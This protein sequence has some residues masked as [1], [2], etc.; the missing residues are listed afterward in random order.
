VAPFATGA[1]DL[2]GSLS[3]IRILALT[4][5]ALAMAGCSVKSFDSNR[6]ASAPAEKI[7]A[8][9]ATF[10]NVA[11]SENSGHPVVTGFIDLAASAYIQRNTNET[12][13]KNRAEFVQVFTQ[14]FKDKLPAAADKFGLAISDTA[15]AEFRV[16]VLDEKTQCSLYGCAS[17]FHLVG[18]LLDAS[19]KSVW[20]FDTNI[21]QASIFAKIPELFDKFTNEVLPAM[22]KDG[23][24]GS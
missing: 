21:G 2:G 13:D 10:V 14:G 19:G 5:A 22:K 24:I 1:D 3:T 7:T 9:R 18:D 6:Q 16:S 4:A 23:V 11:E 17:R 20:H 15:Q 8:A 12:K